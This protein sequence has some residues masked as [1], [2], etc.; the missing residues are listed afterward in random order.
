MAESRSDTRQ[1]TSRPGDWLRL[2]NAAKIFPASYSDVSPEVYRVLL[3]FDAPIRL[4]ALERA[5]AR[6]ARRTPY[7]QVH[8]RRGLFWY[9][10]ERHDR[11]P[12]IHLLPQT[13]V[14]PIALERREE[15][16]Y[17]VEARDS[18]LAIDF[19]H[20]LTDGF[21]A[22]RMLVSL[23]AEYLRE[24]G[25]SVPGNDYLLDPDAV[26]LDGEFEDA[27]KVYYRRGI[28]GPEHLSPAYHLPGIRAW[29]RYRS[30]TGRAPVSAVKAAANERGASITEYLTAVYMYALAQIHARQRGSRIK[31]RRSVIR[32]EV[33]V[34]LRRI[35]RSE[36]MRNFSLFVMP[37]I[38]LRLGEYGLEEIVRA[39]HHAMRTQLEE[40]QL[41]R[42]ISR[43]VAGEQHPVVRAVPLFMK[44]WYLAFLHDRYGDNLYSGVISNLGPMRM[45]A[46]MEEHVRGAGFVLGPNPMLKKNLAVV[47]LSDELYMTFGSVIEPRHL[48]R[49]VF[50]TLVDHGISTTVTE[51][52]Q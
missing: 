12:D 40:K 14:S 31:P 4:P 48:E 11:V 46:E 19:S 51:A 9:Y 37:E 20:I 41:G 8:L 25:V 35:Y 10:L 28:P 32:V 23:G 39:V 2:D 29:R 52:G 13:P 33:P 1:P 30:I 18:R 5:L 16:L 26:P 45:P 15:P 7:Y 24:C 34:N 17:R 49:I 21:G 43:N 3:R 36:T 27:Y 42:Q 6:I 44:D 50:R 38:D 22:L 47:S